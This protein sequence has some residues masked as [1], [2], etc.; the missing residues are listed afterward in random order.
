MK[1]THFLDPIPEEEKSKVF[2]RDLNE[3][4]SSADNDRYNNVAESPEYIEAY[5]K[6][7]ERVI[8]A[9]D[10]R[11]PSTFAVYGSAERYYEDSF[12]YIY[13]SYPYDGSALE[14]INWSL[15]ASAVDLA[16]LQHEYP[17]ETGHVTFTGDSG[18][19]S[20]SATSGIYGL[21]GTPEY[22][23]FS[24]GP[25]VGTVYDSDT[26][27]GSSLKLDPSVG[28]TVEF[29]LKKNSFVESL[30]RSEIVFDS[31]TID[32]AE[33]NAKYGRFLLELSASSE[34]SPFYLTYMSGTAGADRQRI[35]NNIT[36]DDIADGAFHH[37]AFAVHHTGSNLKL[38]LYVDGK[39]NDSVS[40]A[41]A[42][43][44]AVSGY[45]NAA[46]GALRTEKDSNGGLG[47]GKLSG[48][49]DEFRFW[50]E[51]RTAE[52]IHNYYDFPVNGAT[53]E[54]PI[55]SVLGVYYKFNEGTVSDDTK[56]KVVLDYSGRLNNG[57]LV[58]Y[59]ASSRVST[60]AIT[61]SSATSQVELGDPIINKLSSRVTTS[62][63]EFLEIGKTYDETN[64]SSLMKSVPQWAYDHGAGSSNVDSDFSI[65][66]QAIGQKFDSIRMLIDGLPKI[67]FARY[68]DFVYARG[69]TGYQ[70]N[71][72]NVLGCEREY[73]FDF[74]EISQEETFSVQNLLGRGFTVEQS[75]ISNKANLNQYLYNLKFDIADP[76]TNLSQAFAHSKIEN[77]KNK[78]LNTIHAN[79][80]NIFKTKGTSQSFRNLIRCFGVDDNLVA[81]NI[82][83]QNAERIVTNEPVFESVPIK[84]L[85]F[86][87]SNNSMTLHQT[88]S[89]SLSDERAYVES[90]SSQ[91]S[92]TLENRTLFPY[93]LDYSKTAVTSSVFGMNSVSGSDLI[94]TNP[95]N[96]GILVRT[97]KSNV[98]NN[99][100]YFSLTSSTGMFSE[101]KSSYFNEVYSNTPWYLSV[102]F[103]EDTE[104]PLLDSDIRSNPSY[105][106]EFIGYRYD[107]DVETSTFHLSASITETDYLSF[108]GS[109]KSFFLGANRT[110][111]T[112]AVINTSDIKALS[113]SVWDDALSTDEMKEHAK[114]IENIGRKNPLFSKEDN[115]GGSSMRSESLIMNWQF[116]DVVYSDA[117]TNYFYD[118]ASGSIDKITKQ[119]AITGYKY[120]AATLGLNVQSGSIQQEY[121]PSIKYVNPDNQSTSH[122]FIYL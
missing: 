86:T 98:Q 30:T 2:R 21:S 90:K 26:N 117:S 118:H 112:G 33:G 64:H 55:D 105:K 52:D 59:N 65:L 92:M 12:T 80:S 116:D 97:L 27:R 14:K 8:P 25:Y 78:I 29:W 56:D 1:K 110:Q 101:L 32:F 22:I 58:G 115:Q 35:G 34:G 45:F 39:F 77:L 5:R 91:L 69:S 28:N 85:S 50:K 31:H 17:F 6:L 43:F 87:G 73:D 114:S 107:L 104:T 71:F 4:V 79:I 9:I 54:E 16:I 10:V 68:K 89:N 37:Y 66:L 19:G 100:C 99:G 11:D 108:M 119:G 67:G 60:S 109:N 75:P 7:A 84:S 15:S 62:L 82:Y 70:D 121:L 57:E 72:Y 95:N 106:V 93:V 102:R 47:Y 46:I 41:A 113:F 3:T 20:L 51:R 23:K 49:V 18:W 83:A 38:E 111:L 96:A 36:S 24:G 120:P 63:S 94:V 76:K 88:A 122:L 74:K 40:V 42:S 44:G 103:S 13:N 48:S 81:P 61:L 53:D